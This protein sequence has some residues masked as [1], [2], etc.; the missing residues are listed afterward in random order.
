MNLRTVVPQQECAIYDLHIILLRYLSAADEQIK[1][2]LLLLAF[3]KNCPASP[4]V[5]IF[6]QIDPL[7]TSRANNA[8]A[9]TSAFRNRLEYFCARIRL[10][11][12][13]LWK[14][15]HMQFML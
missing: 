10:C 11:F 12:S 7:P 14:Q 3:D 5:K 13:W 9:F 1:Q 2:E 6:L 8:D 15:S 4:N